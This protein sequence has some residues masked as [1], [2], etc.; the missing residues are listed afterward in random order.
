MARPPRVWVPEVDVAAAG[1]TCCGCLQPD[2]IG[3]GRLPLAGGQQDP[4]GGDGA[5]GGPGAPTAVSHRPD[6]ERW[7][8]EARPL[9][10]IRAGRR[11]GRG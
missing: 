1:P 5:G 8:Q 9:S 10:L 2:W 6:R 3:A 7:P 4:P 11:R